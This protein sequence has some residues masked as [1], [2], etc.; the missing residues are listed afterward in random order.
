MLF[1]TARSDAIDRT[2]DAHVETLR[3]KLKAVAPE[4]EPI[5]TLRGT[6]YA[7]NEDLPAGIRT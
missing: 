7:L 6:G 1:L 5:R 3:A 4:L 2:V